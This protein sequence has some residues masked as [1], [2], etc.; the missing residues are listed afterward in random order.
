MDDRSA[1]K[2]S[3]FASFCRKKRPPLWEAA[4]K[5]LL[6]AYFGGLFGSEGCW[7]SPGCDG[8]PILVPIASPETIISTRRFCC[9]PAAVPLDAT[10]IDLPSPVA[11][12][13]ASG[14]P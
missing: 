14:T 4:V 9:R 7:L 3:R 12:R 11:V 10:G 2:V 13:L 8:P 6:K 5:Q 1:G